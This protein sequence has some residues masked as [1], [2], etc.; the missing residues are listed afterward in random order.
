MIHKN[1]KSHKLCIVRSLLAGT[2]ALLLVVGLSLLLS[3]FQVLAQPAAEAT[4]ANL[5]VK[6]DVSEKYDARPGDRLTYT[7]RIWNDGDT[8][9]YAWLTDTLPSELTIIP[10]SIT[11]SAGTFG[12]DNNVIT[13]S[14]PNLGYQAFITFVTQ[15]SPSITSLTITNTAQV[16]GSGELKESS[17]ATTVAVVEPGHPQLEASKSVYPSWARPGELLT[18]TVSIT[19]TGDGDAETV[20]MTDR[21]PSLVTYYTHSLTATMGTF[22]EAGGVITWNATLGPAG[23]LLLPFGEEATITFTV[24]ISPEL[25]Q[26]VSFT[27]TAEITGAGS[28]VLAR[29]E[30]QVRTNFVLYLPLLLKRWPPVPYKP[31]LYEIG[32]LPEGTNDFTVRW[33]HDHD[34]VT[35]TS[36]TLQEA[37]DAWFTVNVTNIA[38]PH[39]PTVTEY[40]QLFT[41][42]PDGWYYYRVQA[43]NNYGDS[44]W[45]DVKSVSVFTV[46]YDDFNDISSGWPN[47]K[48]PIKDDQGDTH[49]YWH[50]RYYNSQYRIYIEQPTCWTCGW[51][52]QPDALAPYRPATD[53]YCVETKVKFQQGAYWASLGLVFGADEANRKIYALCLSRGGDQD[54]LGGF[55]MRKDDYSLP[56][57]GCSGPT[58]KIE[59]GSEGTSRSDWNRLQIGVD[60]DKVKV[61]MGGIYKGEWTMTGL[62]SMTRVGVIGGDYEI[63][64]V[65]IRYEYFRVLPNTACTP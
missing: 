50:R 1:S 28:L 10:E 27:N 45:S 34:D 65:D 26:N 44:A 9:T 36:Y 42:K 46:Y 51:F 11:T 24:R 48:R 62:S 23:T 15:I 39:T 32:P 25:S 57:R 30:A 3:H 22:G 29:A 18:Y 56:M 16:T 59:V 4:A 2:S 20:W 5:N 33:S 19:N 63:L 17:A 41:D 54:R 6:K 13:W 49:G 38:I 12:V 47:E 52:Y 53:K 60:G 58:L 35:V 31:E 55:L 61:Y 14:H 37:A 21:L 64:P 7:I 43:H 8:G 40:E